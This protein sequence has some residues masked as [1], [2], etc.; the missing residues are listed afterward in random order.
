MSDILVQQ[1]TEQ[2]STLP[3]YMQRQ[4]LDFVLFLKQRNLEGTPGEEVLRSAMENR[5]SHQDS[6]L[7]AKAIEDEFEKIEPDEQ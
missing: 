4:V 3:D 2:V 5:I 7:I 1:L 6:V